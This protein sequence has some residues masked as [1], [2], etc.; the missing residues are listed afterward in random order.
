MQAVKGIQYSTSTSTDD[1]LQRS[2]EEVKEQWGVLRSHSY[3]VNSTA[4]L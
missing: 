4:E 3:A 1:V 2:L